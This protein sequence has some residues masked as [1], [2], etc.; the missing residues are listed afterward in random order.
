MAISSPYQAD[1]GLIWLRA[2]ISLIWADM[3]G[4][5]MGLRRL[6][7][8]KHLNEIACSRR[9]TRPAAL[10]RGLAPPWA[11]CAQSDDPRGTHPPP[12]HPCP[13]PMPKPAQALTDN[14][15]CRGV[16]AQV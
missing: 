1:M 12:L 8:S 4:V 7:G 14:V 10:A 15:V 2:H 16:R 11:L 6:S 5:D 3:G 9:C 13:P